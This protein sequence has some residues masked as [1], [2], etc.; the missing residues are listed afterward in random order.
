MT[1]SETIQAVIGVIT[2]TIAFTALCRAR[3]AEAKASEID[4]VRD[5]FKKKS[6][7]IEE[8]MLALETKRFGLEQDIAEA[9]LPA[10]VRV[11]IIP[12]ETMH[13]LCFTNEGKGVASDIYLHAAPPELPASGSARRNVMG[14]KREFETVDYEMPRLVPGGQQL[15]EVQGQNPPLYRCTITWENP[16]GKKYEDKSLNVTVRLES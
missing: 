4:F 2:V 8:R 16:D 15:K 5:E 13:N 9:T 6:V 10:N 12:G 14:G 7:R 11:S 3:K 1:T